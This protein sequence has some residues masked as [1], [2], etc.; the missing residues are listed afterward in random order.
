MGLFSFARTIYL[1]ELVFNPLESIVTSPLSGRR[2]LRGAE[3]QLAEAVPIRRVAA[4]YFRKTPLGGL[5]FVGFY[6]GWGR[7]PLHFSPSLESFMQARDALR[8]SR[9]TEIVAD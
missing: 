8:Q 4:P 5:P 3:A 6:K 7:S 9:R 2:M 1:S